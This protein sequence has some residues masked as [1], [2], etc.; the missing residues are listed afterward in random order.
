MHIE[1]TNQNTKRRMET[2]LIKQ[3]SRA[4]SMKKSS[5]ISKDSRNLSN[6]RFGCYFRRSLVNFKSLIIPFGTY[7][8]LLEYMVR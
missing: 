4:N 7:G 5:S 2:F 8:F 6:P 3:S 1:S